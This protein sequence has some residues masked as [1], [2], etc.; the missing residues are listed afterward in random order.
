MKTRAPPPPLGS[1]PVAPGGCRR[2]RCHDASHQGPSPGR[3]RCPASWQIPLPG[4]TPITARPI[5][6]ARPRSSHGRPWPGH[7]E[8]RHQGDAVVVQQGPWVEPEPREC[9][10]AVEAVGI[11][12][13]EFETFPS[14]DVPEDLIG[15]E[16]DDD[17]LEDAG[18]FVVARAR[19]EVGGARIG[20]FDDQLRRAAEILPA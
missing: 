19:A 5:R 1:W 13:N 16:R 9:P 12:R 4:S 14:A 18:E 7:V 10:R 2:V 8:C 17:V 15:V 11:G 20:D 6:P 3:A